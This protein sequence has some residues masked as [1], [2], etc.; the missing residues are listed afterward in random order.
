M[1]AHCHRTFN[2]TANYFDAKKSGRYRQVFVVTK[3]FD[4]K[5]SLHYS[6]VLVVTELFVSGT[7][8][9]TIKLKYTA[10]NVYKCVC[11]IVRGRREIDVVSRHFCV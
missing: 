1:G 10:K 2:I 6:R 11:S 4:A 7:R 3:F 8:F 5:T 9:T